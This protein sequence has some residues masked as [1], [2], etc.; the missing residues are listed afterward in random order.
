MYSPA[1]IILDRLAAGFRP[2]LL[3]TILVAAVALPGIAAV[4]PLDRD[5]ARFAVASRQM[6]ES[7][8]WITV[9]FQDQLRAKKPPGIYW[10][11][12]LTAEATGARDAIWVYRVPSVLGLL[13]AVLALFRLAAPLVG[14]PTAL[15]AAALLAVAPLAVSE[16]HQAKTDAV[17]LAC[18]VIAQGVLARFYFAARRGPSSLDASEPPPPDIVAALI[19]WVAQAAAIMIKGPIVPAISLLT[20]VTLV[21]ADRRQPG[22]AAWL[23]RLRPALG[24]L[25]IIVLDAPWAIAVSLATQGRFINEAA[26]HD[27][28]G[29]LIEPQESHEGMFGTYLG[30]SVVTLWPVIL[31]IVPGLVR[32]FRT[33]RDPVARFCLAWAVPS[34]I[35]FEL[36]PT[37]L[38]HY[39]LPLVPAL[40]VLAAIACTAGAWPTRAWWL[41]VMAG[42]AILVG[43]LLAVS[44]V[45]APMYLG[46]GVLPAALLCAAAALAAGLL[47]GVLAWRGR[48][49]VAAAV[50][51][52]TAAATWSLLFAGLLPGLQPLWVSQR[53]AQL[54]PRDAPVAAAGFHEPSL[55]FLLG[56]GTKLTDGPGAAD[57]LAATPH[58]AAIITARDESAFQQRL[59]AVGRTAHLLG[60]VDGLN[61]SHGRP[62]HL[63]VWSLDDAGGAHG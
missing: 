28:L 18:A 27:L 41:R 43:V 53:V 19:F 31:F 56:S 4:P 2:Y 58:A 30:L 38:P 3:L 26:G 34:W 35:M 24:L 25:L 45:A 16:A 44:F 50:A 20:V 15:L 48:A 57:Y 47:S 42:L 61:Y 63:S 1:P 49:P 13:V 51:V 21:I 37:K 12:A 6:L 23:R 10:L 8:D 9:R 36:V 52:V 33:R 29:K 7:G 32:A 60:A 40:T 5:E 14:R 54:V 59:A 11:Q 55:V 39:V 46:Q 17:L 62:V 22:G